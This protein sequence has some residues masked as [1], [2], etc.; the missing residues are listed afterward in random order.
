MR[1]EGVTIEQKRGY[2]LRVHPNVCLEVF[3]HLSGVEVRGRVI[4]GGV[5]LT[6][7]IWDWQCRPSMIDA[8]MEL[9]DAALREN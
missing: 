4:S 8:V 6:R 2:V 5:L 1:A 9:L 3:P 7:S